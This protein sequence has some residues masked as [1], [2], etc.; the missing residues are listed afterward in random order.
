MARIIGTNANNQLQGTSDDDLLAGRGG[1]D[2]L[3]G[4]GSDTAWYGGLVHEYLFSTEDGVLTLTDRQAT[5]GD[6]GTD[7]LTTIE[8]VQFS[9]ARLTVTSERRVNST[10]ASNQSQS[11]VTGLADGGY[12]VT[13]T[14]NGQDGSGAGIYAQRYDTAGAVVGGEVRVNTET[15]SIQNEPAVTAL[16][17]GGYVVTWTSLDQDEAGT[18]GIY[19]QRYDAEG[20]AVD[21][22]V[23]VNSTTVDDQFQPAVTGLADGGFVVTWTSSGQDAGG[24]YG[25]YAQRY[26]ATGTAV[27][28]EVPVNTEAADDQSDSAV[29]ALADGGYVVTWTSAGQDGFGEGLYDEA[30]RVWRRKQ[31]LRSTFLR[32]PDLLRDRVLTHE[33]QRLL[34]ELMSE[35]VSMVPMYDAGGGVR[36]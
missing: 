27:G 16:T 30:I 29:A 1:D 11:V 24:T 14:S 5:N 31:A 28:G 26:D 17:D 6:E 19:V 9:D 13:W 22:E 8:Q 15:A 35:D 23:L 25:I 18:F 21:G 32:R 7:Q 3:T 33:D 34:N 2:Q 20:T 10:T 12:V 36:S 4:G